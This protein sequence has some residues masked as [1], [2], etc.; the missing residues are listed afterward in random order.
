MD[1]LNCI[2][3]IWHGDSPAAQ[4]RHD[5]AFNRIRYEVKEEVLPINLSHVLEAT[6][7]RL[8]QFGD[9]VQC[10]LASN[11]FVD[12]AARRADELK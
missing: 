1:A 3:I 9:R 2:H 4:V 5:H 8:V 12:G 10:S 7:A 11:T 6:T